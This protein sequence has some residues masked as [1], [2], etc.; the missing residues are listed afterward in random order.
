MDGSMGELIR[1]KAEIIEEHNRKVAELR[2]TQ[3]T[4]GRRSLFRR[5]NEYFFDIESEE[6][7]DWGAVIW[8]YG[9]M[10]GIVA[11]GV[12]TFALA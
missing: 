7:T 8:Y 6:R 11:V 9:T 12:A 5:M 3:R 1:S 4:G 10:V 2:R